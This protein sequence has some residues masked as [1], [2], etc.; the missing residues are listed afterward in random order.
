[1]NGLNVLN[2][3]ILKN[4]LDS[5]SLRRLIVVEKELE[6][7]E[8]IRQLVKAND[9]LKNNKIDLKKLTIMISESTNNLLKEVLK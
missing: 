4:N 1:M 8:I 2:E 5:G 9:L 6:A 3:I 7:L